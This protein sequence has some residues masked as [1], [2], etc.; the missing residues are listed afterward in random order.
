MNSF[1]SFIGYSFSHMFCSTIPV[2]DGMIELVCGLMQKPRIYLVG[3]LL[4]SPCIKIRS[5]VDGVLLHCV[6]GIFMFILSTKMPLSQTVRQ[7]K[8]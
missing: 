6:G 8:L 4:T 2:E 5:T 7:A 3:L 1:I